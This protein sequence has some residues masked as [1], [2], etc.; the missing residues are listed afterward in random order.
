ML[1]QVF[2]AQNA[3]TD[4][5][6][7]YRAELFQFPPARDRANKVLKFLAEVAVNGHPMPGADPKKPPN[8]LKPVVPFWPAQQ[9]ASGGQA[10]AG[11]RLGPEVRA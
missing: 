6:E 2:M 7:A 10:P 11:L 1:F 5:I 4:F 9:D 8:A 3:K